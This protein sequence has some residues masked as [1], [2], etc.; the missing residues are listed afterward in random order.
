[1]IEVKQIV[2]I[3]EENGEQWPEGKR[4]IVSSHWNH[5][6][7]V[8]LKVGRREFAVLAR[9]LTTA[10]ENATNINRF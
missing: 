3:V 1:M 7:W 2:E 10:I 9:D 5:R 4:I 6:E 8:I